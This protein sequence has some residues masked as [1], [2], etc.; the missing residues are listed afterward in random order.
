[1]K[2]LILQ[3]LIR[4][5]ENVLEIRVLKRDLKLVESLKEECEKEF[6]EVI[7]FIEVNEKRV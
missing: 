6:N 5:S 1:M 4:M 7:I 2:K 3:C